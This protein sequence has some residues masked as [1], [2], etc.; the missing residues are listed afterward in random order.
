MFATEMTKLPVQTLHFADDGATPN[1]RFPVLLYR[2]QPDPGG[3]SAEASRRAGIF[4]YH[5]YHPTP[6][7]CWV[8]PVG[9]RGS[10][11]VVRQGRR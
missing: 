10:P 5:H 6:T 2:L 4:D 3:D 9:R 7:R 11:W 8:S 1:S